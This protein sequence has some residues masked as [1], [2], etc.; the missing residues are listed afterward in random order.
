MA[1]TPEKRA[2]Q[3]ILSAIE[4]GKLSTRETYQLVADAD[5]TLIHLIFTWL[6]ARYPAH[7]PASDGVLGRL[8]ELCTQYPEAAAKAKEGES[9]SLVAWFE[10]EYDYRELRSGDFIDL[11]VEKLES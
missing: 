11:I 10:D 9:D 2:A 7:N 8:A 1:F 4:D 5:P 6:R 3:R